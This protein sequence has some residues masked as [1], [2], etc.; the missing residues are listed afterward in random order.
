MTVT[1]IFFP[2]LELVLPFVPNHPTN[3]TACHHYC[4]AVFPSAPAAAIVTQ[5]LLNSFLTREKGVFPE[6]VFYGQTTR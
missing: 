6:L 4:R 2:T 1:R 3:H 5:M